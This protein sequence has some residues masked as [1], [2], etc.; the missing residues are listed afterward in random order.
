[1]INVSTGNMN[2]GSEEVHKKWLEEVEKDIPNWTVDEMW[3]IRMSLY[4]AP[5]VVKIVTKYMMEH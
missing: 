1:M 4:T 5:E 3:H 2:G